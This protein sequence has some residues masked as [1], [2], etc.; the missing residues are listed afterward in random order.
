MLSI[1]LALDA[2]LMIPLQIRIP[3]PIMA[4][5]VGREALQGLSSPR[6]SDLK[7]EVAVA[8]CGTKD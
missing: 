2:L 6:G 3:S 4:V 1:L 7:A 5:A 8:P